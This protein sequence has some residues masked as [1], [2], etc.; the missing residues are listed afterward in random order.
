MLDVTIGDLIDYFGI[1]HEWT[2]SIILYVES[3]TEAREFMS[4]ARAFARK[5]PIVAYKAGRFTQSAEA[6]ASHTGA[7][8]GVDTVYE[9][10]LNRAGIVRI[11]EMTDMFDC[12]ELLARQTAPKGPRLAIVTN[13]GGPG[14]MATDALMSRNGVLADLS[15]DT[16]AK[17]G[18]LLPKAWSQ[19]NPVDV[20]GDATPERLAGARYRYQRRRRRCRPGGICAAGHQ[21]AD[22]GGRNSDPRGEKVAQADPHLLDGRGLHVGSDRPV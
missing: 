8:A 13:A 22:R 7:L 21:Q 1:G 5:K 19:R 11:D 12:A 2:E 14:V 9:A 16:F 20:L 17:L 15:A 6:A 10:A 4:A 18:E 3:I